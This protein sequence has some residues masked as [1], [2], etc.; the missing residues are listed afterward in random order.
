[1]TP[2]EEKELTEHSDLSLFDN[3]VNKLSIA[4]STRY[5]RVANS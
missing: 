5:L 4:F 3:T 2:E 1:M